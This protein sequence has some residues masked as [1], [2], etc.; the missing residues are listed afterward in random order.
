MFQYV[1]VFEE[2]TDI[3]GSYTVTIPDVPE[4]ITQGEGL[5]DAKEM[6]A[7]ALELI[8]SSYI[9]KGKELPATKSR[10]GRNGHWIVPSALAQMKLTLYVEFRKSRISRVDLARRMGI[11][12]Q[13]VDRLFD[14]QHSSRVEQ[15]E[16]AFH[17][18]GKSMAISVEDA[19]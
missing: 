17:A 14:L 12:K 15:L 16:L 13:Q 10:K 9:E 19:A 6:A 18:L 5:A 4:V 7:D 8:L 1:G 2:C 3:P 11:A